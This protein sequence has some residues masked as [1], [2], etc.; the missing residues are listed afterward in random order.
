MSNHTHTTS[1][2]VLL[3]ILITYVAKQTHC[4]VSTFQSNVVTEKHSLRLLSFMVA[5]IGAALQQYC[6]N[7][8]RKKQNSFYN[9]YICKQSSSEK[10][11]VFLSLL[12]MQSSLLSIEI[13][14]IFLHRSF[15]FLMLKGLEI[16]HPPPLI[17]FFSTL[18]LQSEARQMYRKI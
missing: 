18:P 2:P 12:T 5:H 9:S 16:A 17:P 10:P 13:F 3:Q 6:S 15:A 14:I 7:Y 4:F 8:E 11:S 1:F